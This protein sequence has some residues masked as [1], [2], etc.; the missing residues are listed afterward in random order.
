MYFV[1]NSNKHAGML[2]YSMK[3]GLCSMNFIFCF[4]FYMLFRSLKPLNIFEDDDGFFL[5]RNMHEW[6]SQTDII[7][8]ID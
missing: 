2:Q 4:P 1:E 6:D 7:F 3:Y 8:S 5:M